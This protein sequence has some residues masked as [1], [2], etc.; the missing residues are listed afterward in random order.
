MMLA[1]ED[2][3]LLAIM[4]GLF[5]QERTGGEARQD[6][7]RDDVSQHAEHRAFTAERREPSQEEAAGQRPE[8]E[9]QA[10][11]PPIRPRRLL[12][13][14]PSGSGPVILFTRGQLHLHP[15]YPGAECFKASPT[16]ASTFRSP[17]NPSQ[18]FRA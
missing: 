12:P 18:P 6:R 14:V 11:R 4:D 13:Q 2:G 16:A 15:T 8:R 5:P 10:P 3:G 7:D 9:L 17:G 1:F